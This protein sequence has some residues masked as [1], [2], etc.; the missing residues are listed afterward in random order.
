MGF[1]QYLYLTLNKNRA[2][3]EAVVAASPVIDFNSIKNQIEANV[4]GDID[5]KNAIDTSF[6]GLEKAFDAV[7]LDYLEKNTNAHLEDFFILVVDAK[8]IDFLN[9]FA[10]REKTAAE[11]IVNT[12]AS[13][14]RDRDQTMLV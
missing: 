7:P 11:G 6:E 13:I 8:R 4:G 5:S 10:E 3:Y 14:D 2:L 12:L 1:S 9:K